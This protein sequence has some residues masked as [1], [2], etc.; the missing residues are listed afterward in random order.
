MPKKKAKG[1]K[2]GKKVPAGPPIITT[3]DILHERT[4]MNC[5]RMGDS[6]S[7]MINVETILGVSA[8]VLL[9]V[10][11]IYRHLC[12]IRCIGCGFQDNRKGSCKTIRTTKPK[13]N[14]IESASCI[15]SHT[16]DI[17]ELCCRSELVEE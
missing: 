9:N 1:K 10:Q 12:R 2:K 8:V 6:Y 3:R 7:K 11:I 17:L 15:Q 4:K 14:E 13:S 5:P 16:I